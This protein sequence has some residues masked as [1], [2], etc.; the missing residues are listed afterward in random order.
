LALGLI[1]SPILADF[2][3]RPI[4]RRILALCLDYGA[5][6][7]RFVDDIAV[8]AA[9][10]VDQTPIPVRIARILNSHGLTAKEKD[11]GGRLRKGVSI[12]GVRLKDL[13][14]DAP[15]D[16][17]LELE[18]QIDDH[19][20]LARGDRFD[21]PL[22]SSSQLAGRVYHAVW[23]NSGRRQH[24]VKR[25]RSIRWGQVWDHARR[26]GVA[27]VRK[28]VTARGAPAPN[29]TGTMP[30]SDFTSAWKNPAEP[31]PEACP[32]D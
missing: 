19:L 15:H 12:T 10:D 3:L 30:E 32:F 26:K 11:P 23:L 7:S 8:S 29:F 24:L 20:S 6:Y 13:R 27:V 18:R 22:L 14:T 9:F 2:I 1:T 17:I 21:G 31:T 16:Y 28:V 5:T 25:Y 4:D